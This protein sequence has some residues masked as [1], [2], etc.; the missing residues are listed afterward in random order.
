MNQS[1][2]WAVDFETTTDENDC[3]VWAYGGCKIGQP[4]NFVH[5]INITDFFKWCKS[6]KNPTMYFHNLKFD[7]IFLITHLIFDMGF[8]WVKDRDEAEENTFTTLISD[9]GQFYQ[10]EVYF[11]VYSSPKAKRKKFKSVTFL[12]S[13]KKIPFPVKVVAKA[14]NLSIKKGELD[15]KKFRPIGH[16]LTDDELDYLRNDVQIMAEALHIQFEQGLTAMTVGSDALNGYK[17]IEKH[18][19]HLFPVLPMNIDDEIRKAYRGGFTYVAKRYQGRDIGKGIVFDVT[20]L[21]PSVMYYR[22]L[23]WGNP[24]HFEGRYQQDDEMPLFIQKMSC[25]FKIKDKHIPTIQVKHNPLFSGEEYLESSEVEID[26]E[27]V[28]EPV[29]LHLSSVDLMLF[30]KHYKIWNVEFLGGWKFQECTGVFKEYIDYWIGV[31]EKATIEKNEAIRTLSKLMLNSIYGKFA[32]SMDVTGKHAIKD[33]DIIR[34]I[35]DHHEWDE[36]LEK[37]VP[38]DDLR[39]YKDPVYTAMGVFITSWA[40]YITIS[41]A[42][43]NYDRFI[44]ADTDSLHLEGDE[45]PKD[46]DIDPIRLGAWKHECTFEY[47]RFLRPKTYVEYYND[48]LHVTACGMPD[49][50]KAHVTWENFREGLSVPGKLV[51]KIVKG[52]VVLEERNFTII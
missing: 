22:K 26:G 24:E 20:S 13:L 18:F 52:G 29:T 1:N 30:T 34:F 2:C 35:P 19:N 49:P 23:P 45:M 42:Q 16:Q 5:G 37:Y 33:G 41:S 38:N 14:F 48:K 40:R 51:P 9:M 47:G 10:I 15:Y 6:E 25:C 12:D 17:K 4:N 8:K 3:R 46:L 31:K 21:Y 32:S 44:Y 50:C 28:D 11:K 39:E 36:K 27:I 7:G 43:D